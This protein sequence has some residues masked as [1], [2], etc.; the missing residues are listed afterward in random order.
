MHNIDGGC[1][2]KGCTEEGL[3][4][5]AGLGASCYPEKV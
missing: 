5:R 3:C 2:M 1:K 4:T